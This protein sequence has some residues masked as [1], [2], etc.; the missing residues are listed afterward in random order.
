MKWR[1]CGNCRWSSGGG[2]VCFGLPVTEVR[3]GR[4]HW[5]IA[6]QPSERE[7]RQGCALF[8]GDWRRIP[9]VRLFCRQDTS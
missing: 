6:V 4:R 8:R 7:R 3:R 9:I 2:Y 5:T 1:R